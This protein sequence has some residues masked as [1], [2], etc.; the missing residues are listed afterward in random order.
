MF[1][2]VRSEGG[3]TKFSSGLCLLNVFFCGF[4]VT[5]VKEVRGYFSSKYFHEPADEARYSNCRTVN[6]G[7]QHSF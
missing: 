2:F 5:L 1:C 4:P 6:A 7:G 3:D